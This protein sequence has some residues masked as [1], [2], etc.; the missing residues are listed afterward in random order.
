MTRFSKTMRSENVDG[1]AIG[2]R[3][4]AMTLKIA[5]RGREGGVGQPSQPSSSTTL[6]PSP[7]CNTP[8]YSPA[9]S[10]QIELMGL[11]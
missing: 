4:A 2:E 9:W 3:F 10:F 5:F 1:P 8:S 7:K 6:P 11:R